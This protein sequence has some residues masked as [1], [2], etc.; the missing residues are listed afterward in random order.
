[1]STA[2]WPKFDGTLEEA[3]HDTPEEISAT[4]PVLD[5]AQIARLRAFGEELRVGPGEILFDQGDES[6]GVF[7]VLDGSIE[8]VGVAGS[9][10]TFIRTARRGSFTGE[11]NLL[12]GRR[13]LVRC[14]A[15]EA[16]SLLEIG[17][18]NLRRVFETDSALGEIFLRAFLLRRSYLI[19]HSVGDALLIGSNHSSDTLRIREFLS[20]NGHPHTYVDVERDP[21]VQAVLDQFDV[22]VTDIPVL[23]C[24]GQLVLRNPS[25][26][27]VAECFGLNV[28]IDEGEVYDLIVVGAGPSGLAAAVYGASEGLNV[29]V[30]ESN[31][32]GGQAGSSSRIE[33]Y[34]GFPMGISGQDLAGRAFVQAEKFGAHIAIARVARGLK[35]VRLPYSVQLDDGASVQARSIIVAAGAQYRKLDLPN[36]AQFEGVGIYYGATTVEAQLCANDEVAVVGGGNSAGQAA[37]FLSTHAKHVHLLV[38]GPGLSETMSRYLISRVEACQE[39]T[40]RANTEIEALEGDAQLERVRWRETETGAT[41]TREIQHL[42]LMTGACP[43]TAW[44]QGCLAL[45]GK[46]FVKTGVDLGQDWPLERAPHLLET[47]RP[48]VFAVGDVRSGSV[49]RVASAVGEGSMAVQFVHQVLAE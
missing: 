26:A 37:L 28:G 10:E 15:L 19:G 16:S 30:I 35:C 32:P 20:R 6:H 45:D 29:L 5:D 46:Q 4:F 36:V 12:S 27:E 40:L 49:K 48:G 38:R 33:N 42:F 31:A 13:S 47:S 34:L 8:L 11:V 44:L 25:N 21:D 14:R 18:A 39:I 9:D 24:R 17:R 2:G 23:I 41:E 22:R 3:M 1:L 7:V 43:N